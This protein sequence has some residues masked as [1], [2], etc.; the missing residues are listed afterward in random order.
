MTYRGS[1]QEGLT[2][3]TPSHGAPLST[4][5]GSRVAWLPMTTSRV[6]PAEGLRGSSEDGQVTDLEDVDLEA[7]GSGRPG[8]RVRALALG[9]R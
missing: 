5:Q 9:P 3:A 1:W 8:I 2:G 6:S 7:P 4:G